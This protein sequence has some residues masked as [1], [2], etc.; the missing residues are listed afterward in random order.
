MSETL[1]QDNLCPFC[2]D[3]LSSKNSSFLRI[4]GRKIC[5]ECSQK[6]SKT[7][8]GRYPYRGATLEEAYRRIEHYVAPQ[9]QYHATGSASTTT[10]SKKN[11]C[12]KCHSVN[13]SPIG[14]K[15]KSFSVGKAAVGAM[16]FSPLV[17]VA[18]GMMGGCSKKVQ[19]YCHDCGKIF[20]R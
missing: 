9:E 17:G 13:I 11:T 2:D 1:H 5:R 3:E 16:V 12:P 8:P 18:T 4:E 14:Q 15:S 7:M 19:F 6:L 10:I 20:N